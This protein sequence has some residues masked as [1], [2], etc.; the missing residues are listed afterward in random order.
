MEFREHVKPRCARFKAQK[1]GLATLR[2]LTICGHPVDYGGDC[3]H[4]DGGEV[5]GLRFIVI[6]VV[7]LAEAFVDVV[8]M[9]LEDNS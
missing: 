6:W 9:V 1:V 2:K 3:I 7:E 4:V 5:C 8:S